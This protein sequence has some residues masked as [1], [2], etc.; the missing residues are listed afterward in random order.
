MQT[1]RSR[2]STKI[3]EQ[4]RY[5]IVIGV[6][7]IRASVQPYN[8]SPGHRWAKLEDYLYT[9][10]EVAKS[11]LDPS[12]TNPSFGTAGPSRTGGDTNAGIRTRTGQD[13]Q[14]YNQPR[15]DTVPTIRSVNTELPE[16]PSQWLMPLQKDAG[17]GILEDAAMARHIN[18]L[19]EDM[20]DSCPGDELRGYWHLLDDYYSRCAETG[21]STLEYDGDDDDD[22]DDGTGGSYIG[23]DNW[24]LFSIVQYRT[25]V[26]DFATH[27]I[28][29]ALRLPRPNGQDCLHWDRDAW[30]DRMVA[31][32]RNKAANGAQ[33][34][35][36]M[37]RVWSYLSKRSFFEMLTPAIDQGTHVIRFHRYVIAAIFEA[38]LGSESAEN[39]V[40]DQVIDIL[41][42][43]QSYYASV[44][45]SSREV[46][47]SARRYHSIRQTLKR[48]PRHSEC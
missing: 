47:M 24:N 9:G 48:K 31:D 11:N 37:H 28:V 14:D 12:P 5:E 40:M 4:P 3:G 39:A 25:T 41:N 38:H 7:P 13:H 43:H 27:N 45:R 17:L 26:S 23:M 1:R 15:P 21:R 34:D 2:S 8:E 44:A 6:L 22:D 36:R 16:R 33:L 46:L 10:S 29:D 35:A 18:R 42:R 32:P 19:V 20:K 30:E